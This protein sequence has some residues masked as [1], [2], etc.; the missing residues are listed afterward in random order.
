[1]KDV[2]KNGVF[3]FGG[4]ESGLPSSD[5]N[6]NFSFFQA[7]IPLGIP[8]EEQEEFMACHDVNIVKF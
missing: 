4:G 3:S 7:V 5:S 6:P 1:M 2:N 8:T